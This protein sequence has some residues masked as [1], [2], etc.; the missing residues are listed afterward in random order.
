MAFYCLKL[1]PVQ[2]AR[3]YYNMLLSLLLTR[4]FTNISMVYI[5]YIVLHKSTVI[6]MLSPRKEIDVNCFLSHDSYLLKDCVWM[7][8]KH[9]LYSLN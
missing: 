5:Y 4:V 6:I 1:S 7:V 2:L 8:L 9:Y 3:Y